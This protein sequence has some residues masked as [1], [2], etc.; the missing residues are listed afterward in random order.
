MAMIVDSSSSSSAGE[1]FATAIS[2]IDTI[3]EEF[4]ETSETDQKI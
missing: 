1:T 4:K 3:A 2:D